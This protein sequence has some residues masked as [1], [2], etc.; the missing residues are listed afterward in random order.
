M[1]WIEQV[2]GREV[3]DSRGFPTVEV[4]VVL[5]SGARGRAIVPSGASTGAHEALELRDGGAR[6][7]GKGVLQ[8]VDHVNSVI[9]EALLGLDPL[10]QRDI[11]AVLVELDGTD[12]KSRLGANAILGASLAVAHAASEDLGIPLFA[13]LGG[14]RA[15]LLPVPLMNV[16]NGGKHADNALDVQEFMIAPVGA[17]TFREALRMGAEVFHALRDVLKSRGHSV[18][19]GDE[20]GFAPA[21]ARTEEALELLVEA[22]ER[23]GYRPG[24]DVLL[25]MDVAAS[26]LFRDGRY[27][28]AGE[29]RSLTAEELVDVYADLV[30]RYPVFSIED[31]LAE[32]DWE[33]WAKLTSALGGRVQLVGDDLFVT[34]PARLEEGIRRQVAN[35][36][37]V[38]VN[39]I[40]TLSETFDT[41][42]IAARAGY[43]SILS[44][45]SG[46]TED[47]TIAHLAVATGSGQ[48]KTGAPSRTDRVA[49]YNELLRIEEH[50]GDA[51]L[52]AGT[53]PPFRK[54]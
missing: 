30:R 29:G 26:E 36:V 5:S 46:E 8:A 32:D 39:Q 7:R 20:G 33:G 15:R 25:A 51:A 47:V 2:V 10:R 17:P 50:L 13:Y 9:R 21:L 40:G 1:S 18:N 34:N 12:N 22:I 24:E 52:Y 54:S 44:H 14:A 4:E 23:A 49:K 43:R 19:V 28:F 41:L 48:I 16:L 45:R 27:V 37:L 11:D 6:Y 3:L 31:A 38:K 53:L 35:A 42:D